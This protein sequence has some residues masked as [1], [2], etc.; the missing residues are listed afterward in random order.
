MAW[1][2]A[3]FL[4]SQK[5]LRQWR[6][7]EWTH[8][9]HPKELRQWREEEWTHPVDPTEDF[10]TNIFAQHNKM[11][12]LRA[13]RGADAKAESCVTK[14]KWEKGGHLNNQEVLEWEC[15]EW[16]GCGVVIRAVDRSGWF[17]FVQD[18]A[19]ID[20]MLCDAG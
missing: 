6:E 18:C 9:V 17:T 20:Y 4:E 1:S 19:S 7:K 13:N 2:T 10:A 14:R 15:Q 3:A 12:D 16:R 5:K 11:A 8:R